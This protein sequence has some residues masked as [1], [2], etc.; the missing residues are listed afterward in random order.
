MNRALV[1]AA[2][3]GAL[4]TALPAAD[5][6]HRG[7]TGCFTWS[8]KDGGVLTT[9]VYY[10]NRCAAAHTFRIHWS[11]AASGTEDIRV[12]GGEKG[13]TWSFHSLKPTGFSDLGPA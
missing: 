8:W 2:L 11:S 12:K 4:L 7:T 13:S 6:V 9:T 3:T 10:R 1:A 5:T